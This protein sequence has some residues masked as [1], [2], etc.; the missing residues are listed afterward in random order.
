MEI[1]DFFNKFTSNTVAGTGVQQFFD[2]VEEKTSYA[3]YKIRTE[4]EYLYSLL[5][6]NTVDST[7]EDGSFSHCNLPC[8]EWQINRLSVIVTKDIES[9][10]NGSFDNETLLT[11]GGETKKAVNPDEIFCTDPI[12]LSFC[13]G[14]YLCL[15][16]IYSG[17]LI[18]SHTE[19][20][21]PT[22]SCFDGN[23][24]P[25]KFVP[26]PS[27]IG[28]NRSVKTK[29]AF[30]G[31]SI[32]QGVGCPINSYA[33]Y[34]AVCSENMGDEYAFWNLGIGYGRAEDA[35][36][37]GA[38][39]DKAKQNDVVTVCFGVNDIM[40][41]RGYEQ[42]KALLENI[43]ENLLKCGIKIILQ[44]VPPFCYNEQQGKI[45]LDLN[46]YIKNTLSKKVIAVFDSASVLC[47]DNIPYLSSKYGPHPNE[48]GCKIWGE[49]LASVLKDLTI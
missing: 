2:C 42:I 25:D 29:V 38:W 47:D 32:T 27:M 35:A 3:F 46:D 13:K 12:S 11:F 41:G 14:D 15:K 9:V 34:T 49:A 19:S 28:C 22:Y 20:V 18:P 45:M 5:F 24:L 48:A 17:K 39:S 43:V 26:L 10:L 40:Q 16:I 36:T 6:T 31:D 37:N 23:I 21:I 7:F 30:W 8:G 1:N 4:G 44:T 33:H